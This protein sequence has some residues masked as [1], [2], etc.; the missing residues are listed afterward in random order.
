MIDERRSGESGSWPESPASGKLV[1]G[2]LRR[3]ASGDE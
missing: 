3:S 1:S 2:G